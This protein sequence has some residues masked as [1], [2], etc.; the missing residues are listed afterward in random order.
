MLE[1]PIYGN[2]HDHGS[3][4]DKSGLAKTGL[5]AVILLLTIINYPYDARNH[6]LLGGMLL[7]KGVAGLVLLQ[8]PGEA[9]QPYKP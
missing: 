7:F 6:S 9:P 2:Y 3:I 1:F 4:I 5:M 8:W